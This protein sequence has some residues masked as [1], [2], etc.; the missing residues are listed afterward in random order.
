MFYKRELL[1][2]KTLKNIEKFFKNKWY[3]DEFYKYFFISNFSVI[4]SYCWKFI[5]TRIIDGLGPIGVSK[6]LWLLSDY[7]KKIQNGKIFSYAVIMFLGII[8]F[9]TSYLAKF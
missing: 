2:N 9:F 6:K 7:F 1:K 5:D 3:F 4:S 8:I